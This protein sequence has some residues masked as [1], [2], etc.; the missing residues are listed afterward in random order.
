MMDYW[1]IITDLAI[2]LAALG[3]GIGIVLVLVG[4][5]RT[6]EKHL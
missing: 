5:L 3:T 1:K 4:W 6:R 2:V